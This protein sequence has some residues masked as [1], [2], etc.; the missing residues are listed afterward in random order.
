M[1][2]L[3]PLFAARW[4]GLALALLLAATTLAAGV[5]LLGVSGWFLTGAAITTAAASFN[6]F[7]PSSM[8]RGFSFLRIASRYGERITGHATTLAIL[9]DLRVWL[10]GRLIPLV[11]FKGQDERTGDFVSRLTGD[12]ET[13][14]LVF[15]QVIAPLATALFA[16]LGLGLFLW[17]V[18]PTAMPVAL[19]GLGVSAIG[20]PLLLALSGRRSGAAVIRA[21]SDMRIAALDGVDGQADLVALGAVPLSR[22]AFGAA[23]A[24]V[25]VARLKQA[26]GVALGAGAAQFGAGL[27]VIGVLWTGLQAIETGDIGGPLMVGALLAVMAAFEVTGPILRGAGRIGQ[28]MAAARRM[29]AISGAEPAIRDPARPIALPPGGVLELEGVRFGYSAARPVLAGINLRLGEG[30]RIALVGGSGSGKSTLLGLLLR[31]SD[32]DAGSIRLAGLDIRDI[33]LVDLRS[34]IALLSQDAPVFIGTVRDNLLI[35]DPAADDATLHA[36]LRRARLDDFVRGLPEG[37]D[38]WLGESGATLSAGQARRLCLARTL[39]APAEILLLDEPTAGLDRD[40]EAA[41]LADLVT[42]TAG[43]AVIL[44]THAALPDGAVDRVYRFEAGRLA[45]G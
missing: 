7:G 3:V 9:S 38:S 5:A 29:Q 42:A 44:A 16:A 10:F 24:D 36:A 45:P 8:V 31:L 40:T 6:L 13:L 19:V 43:R 30:E 35:G 28:S 37:L 39:L 22:Q 33:R 4:R 34:R 15:L 26:R 21:M 14:D 18:M 17:F 1:K 41:F 2:V 27:T 20:A 25:R 11:P 32:V 23:A 12:V